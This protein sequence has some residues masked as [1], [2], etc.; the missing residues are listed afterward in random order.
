M[1]KICKGCYLYMQILSNSGF[2]PSQKNVFSALTTRRS[3]IANIYSSSLLH[4]VTFIQ[5][6]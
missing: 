4:E 2:S 6:G 3:D 5:C 1:Q